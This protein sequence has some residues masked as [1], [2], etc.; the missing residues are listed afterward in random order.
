MTKEEKKQLIAQ[1]K[2]AKK[3]ADEL[4]AIY[5]AWDYK[6]KPKYSIFLHEVTVSSTKPNFVE[7]LLE[8][9]AKAYYKQSHTICNYAFDVLACL[10]QIAIV[11][12]IE[13]PFDYVIK[14]DRDF[15]YKLNHLD[16]N[17]EL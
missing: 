12:Q 7:Y 17:K 14:S 3:T 15:E 13:T 1:M 11:A 9:H 6:F 8:I 16:L 5:K 10:I 2:L 4:I